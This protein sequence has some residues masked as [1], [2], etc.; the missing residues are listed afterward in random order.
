[1]LQDSTRRSHFTFWS[2][3]LVIA[4]IFF[5]ANERQE[6]KNVPTQTMPGKVDN[7]A[8][9]DTSVASRKF[10]STPQQ[11]G[12][13]HIPFSPNFPTPPVNDLVVDSRGTLWLATEKGVCSITNGIIKEYSDDKGTFPA[14]QAESIAFDGQK[15]WVG[16]LFGLFSMT[17]SGR[18]EK[19]N[20]ISNPAGELIWDVAF[21]GMNIWVGTQAGAAFM[22]KD[23]KFTLIDSK[24][25]NGGLRHDWCQSI[26]RFAGW[27]VA[28]HDRGISFWN[29]GFKASNPEFWKNIDNAKSG[30]IRP[31]SD[32]TFDGRHI[33]VATS[34]GVLYL[35]T[36]IEKLFSESVSNFISYTT[37]HGLPANRANAIISHRGSVW[38][39][40]D[41]GLAR[42]REEKIQVITPVD[43]TSIS[44]VKA[45]AA[46]GD[47]LWIGTENG[48]QFINTAMVD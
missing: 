5:F 38:I 8:R 4:I 40:T 35:T 21:D 37:L 19:H 33:W 3:I 16:T 17:R 29:T 32:M 42:I 15:I 1:M 46:S 41:N 31:V 20:V 6:E 7:S 45:L 36:P 44:G 9:S 11:K 14:P 23:G 24:V 2:V 25:T 26:L 43:G 10:T 13:L 48:V 47:I 34:K 28:V 18:V 39:G 27:F 30:I 22:N 12:N